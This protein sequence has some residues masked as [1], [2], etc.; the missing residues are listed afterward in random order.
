MLDVLATLLVAAAPVH[1][2]PTP[3]YKPRHHRCHTRA[4]DKAWDRRDRRERWWRN[5]HVSDASTFGGEGTAC[6]GYIDTWGT[7]HKTLPCGTK[8]RLC[9]RPTKC[10]VVTV[11]DRGPYIAGRD[12]DLSTASMGYFGCDG[13]CHGIRS[14][15]L[16]RR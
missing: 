12:W 2:T 5:L 14:E 11:M 10:L 6:G 3:V 1:V 8:V 13:V 7:A 4:C 16:R 9:T 15:V